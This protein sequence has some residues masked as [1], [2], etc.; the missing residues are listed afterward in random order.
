MKNKNNKPKTSG[1]EGERPREPNKR[2]V[3]RNIKADLLEALEDVRLGRNLHGPYK[4]VE[5]AMA[6][7]LED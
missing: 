4:T 2:I 6:A 5:E 3:K 1:M 7:M